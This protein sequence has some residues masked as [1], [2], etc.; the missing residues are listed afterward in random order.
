[1]CSIFFWRNKVPHWL[2]N[3]SKPG[4]LVSMKKIMTHIVSAEKNEEPHYF[5]NTNQARLYFFRKIIH[6]FCEGYLNN[7]KAKACVISQAKK[8]AL[9]NTSSKVCCKR[10]AGR[11]AGES[12]S[13]LLESYFISGRQQQLIPHLPMWAGGMYYGK[14]HSKLWAVFFF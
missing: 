12:C 5:F 2:C 6:F 10:V 9:G 13:L 3:L 4:I 8:Q 14:Y 11:W 1:M 7:N